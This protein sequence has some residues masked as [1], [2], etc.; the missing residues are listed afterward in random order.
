M[1][2]YIEYVIL[3]NL[4][5]NYILLRLTSYTLKLNARKSLCFFSAVIGTI[6]A[7]LMPFIKFN[8]LNQEIF[9]LVSFILKLCFGLFMVLIIKKYKNFYCYITTFFMFLTYTFILGG[10]CFG[11]IYLLNLKTT[12][13]GL[14]IFGFEIPISIFILL[15][16]CY[17]KILFSI[18][19]FVRHKNSFH[20][21]YYDVKLKNCNK[22]ILVTGFLDSGNQI[23]INCNGVIVINYKTLIKLYPNLNIQNLVK[24]SLKETGLKNAEFVNIVNS[25]GNNKM[26]TFTVDEMEIIDEHNKVINL[27]NQVV[28]LAKTNFNGK[29]D[30]LLNPEMF[31]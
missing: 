28:G 2:V 6:F 26:L 14:L 25:G 29:F 7:I 15:G 21:F 9:N 10:M 4:I 1:E 16:C 30:C 11:L 17:L 8:G 12:F 24:G 31:I 27:K 5:I 19:K 20:K 18:I 23:S 22:S 13:S 3:D